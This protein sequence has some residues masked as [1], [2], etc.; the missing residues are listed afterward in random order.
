M[1][2]KRMEPEARKDEI[3]DAALAMAAEC[4][5]TNLTRDAVALR[6]GVASTT[7]QYHFQTMGQ[8]RV[9]VMR[10][11]VKQRCLVVVAQGMAAR[12]PQA[13]KADE[14]LRIAAAGSML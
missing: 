9:E 6:V 2:Q 12:D 10:A 7:V 8:F 5:Y 4:G 3:L 14:D 13:L 11:A 1:K